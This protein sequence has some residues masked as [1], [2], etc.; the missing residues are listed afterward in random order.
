MFSVTL[1][2]LTWPHKQVTSRTTNKNNKAIRCWPVWPLRTAVSWTARAS[3]Q[4]SWQT[5]TSFYRHYYY[6]YITNLPEDVTSSQSEHTNRLLV[7]SVKWSTVGSRAFPV[8][9]P[10][11]WNALPE[12]VTSSQSEHTFRCQLKMWLF[13]MSFPDIWYWLH[14]NFQLTL[15]CSN[16]ETVEGLRYMIWYDIW[17][18]NKTKLKKIK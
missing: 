9:G 3:M 11:S 17:Y 5:V 14:L 4:S 16:F 12:D 7:P 2:Q 6:Y 13:K 1:L 15:D 10:K 8:A 18:E